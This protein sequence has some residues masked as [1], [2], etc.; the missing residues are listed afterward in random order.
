MILCLKVD[1]SICN[2]FV[3][4][5]GSTHSIIPWNITLLCVNFNNEFRVN[6]LGRKWVS[7]GKLF[8][9]KTISGNGVCFLGVR[10]YSRKWVRKYFQVFGLY[11]KQKKFLFAYLTKSLDPT[12]ILQKSHKIQPKYYKI[13]TNFTKSNHNTTESS[14]NRTTRAWGVGLSPELSKIWEWFRCGASSIW[15]WVRRWCSGLIDG[16]GFSVVLERER[17]RVRVR[18]RVLLLQLAARL[19]G[20]GWRWVLGGA[21]GGW[22]GSWWGSRVREW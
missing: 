1:I 14:Q 15:S 22:G 13:H 6:L 11:G 10:L 4:K 7:D 3:V 19:W 16:I 5:F 17:A 12:K 9:R 21:H 8:H 20:L 18:V 2:V